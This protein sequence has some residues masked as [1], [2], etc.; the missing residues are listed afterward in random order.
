MKAPVQK[1][2][3]DA[4][5]SRHVPI[6]QHPLLFGLSDRKLSSYHSIMLACF[7]LYQKLEINI[8][9]FMGNHFIPFDYSVRLKLHRLHKDLR[10]FQLDP[11]IEANR[12]GR[13]VE[14]PQIESLGKLIGILYPIKGPSPG[15]Q[16]IS[17]KTIKNHVVNICKG[18]R[19]F[20]GYAEKTTAHR[21]EFCRLA[22]LIRRDEE[23]CTVAISSAKLV[24]GLFEHVLDDFHRA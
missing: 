2:L 16:F 23:Q 17:N 3:K 5:H 9:V 7:H 11:E 1:R 22:E 4:P 15:E 24:F 10:F 20:N 12:P 8:N 14:I 18:A 6:N 13:S 19:F 21:G